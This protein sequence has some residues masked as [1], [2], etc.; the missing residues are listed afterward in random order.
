M[1]LTALALA[2]AVQA[3]PPLIVN[4]PRARRIEIPGVLAEEATESAVRALR[5]LIAKPPRGG[6]LET[7]RTYAWKTEALGAPFARS[8]RES[9]MQSAHDPDAL[10]VAKVQR[11][12]DL[13]QAHHTLAVLRMADGCSVSSTVRFN[14]GR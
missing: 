9:G 12:G 13:P 6:R 3:D 2:V 14:V 5:P 10:V 7:T 8:C 11:L 1:L 4:P